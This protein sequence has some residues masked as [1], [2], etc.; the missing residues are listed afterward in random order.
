L[1]DCLRG[2]KTW[3]DS[4]RLRMNNSKT[5]FLYIGSR[6]QLSNCEKQTLTGNDA[7]INRVESIKYLGVQVDQQLNLKNHIAAKTRIASLNLYRIKLIRKY[8]TTEACKCVIQA[9]VIS[10]LDYANAVFPGLPEVDMKKLR[11]IHHRAA[12]LI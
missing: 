8:L 12:K 1:E 4:N 10:H 3:M 6:Q 11:R 5:E 9:M 2:I 7:N